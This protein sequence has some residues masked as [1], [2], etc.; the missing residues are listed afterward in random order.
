MPLC[1]LILLILQTCFHQSLHLQW[2]VFA[3]TLFNLHKTWNSCLL[4]GM[5][6]T[7]SDWILS[8]GSVFTLH[9]PQTLTCSTGTPIDGAVGLRRN[10]RGCGGGEGGWLSQ[11]LKL[12]QKCGKATVSKSTGQLIS[13]TVPTDVPAFVSVCVYIC[14][15]EMEAFVLWLCVP[16]D[17][18][19]IKL[20]MASWWFRGEISV[21]LR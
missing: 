12:R 18:V 2:N 16:K 3:A 13:G 1:L 14:W 20:M 11:H 7:A 5:V 15:S 9:R 10:E 21:F 4:A 17:C 6:I 19:V 8:S